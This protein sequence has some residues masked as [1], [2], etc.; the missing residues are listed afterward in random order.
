MRPA[1]SLGYCPLPSRA[2]DCVGRPPRHLLRLGGHGARSKPPGR[3]WRDKSVDET[4]WPRRKTA[5]F[6]AVRINQCSENH[7]A[8]KGAS[9]L[10]L[11]AA[12]ERACHSLHKA[13]LPATPL[14]LLSSLC[15]N[16]S[17]PDC[18]TPSMARS[19]V[20]GKHPRN[21]RWLPLFAVRCQISSC[22][23]SANCVAQQV[24]CKC[25]QILLRAMQ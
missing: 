5:E 1:A 9:L 19:D 6:G 21:P 20:P 11:P 3:L 14:S 17:S 24:R 25:I 18:V 15:L 2:V 10:L 7:G 23:S 4:S 22:N 16:D 8:Q 13:R 12:A